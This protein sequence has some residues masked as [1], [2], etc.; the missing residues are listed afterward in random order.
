MD[1]NAWVKKIDENWKK[2]K[3]QDE[4][5]KQE[6]VLKGRYIQE[7]YADGYAIYQIVRENKNTVRIKVC[8]DIGD[9]WVIPYWGEETT[10]DKSH[11]ERN[12]GH[13]DWMDS[14]VKGKN[15]HL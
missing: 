8:K 5:A 14:L 7:A 11:A 4:K 10:I 13:R 9:D 3:E 15:N 1:T 12:I 6:G 2:I